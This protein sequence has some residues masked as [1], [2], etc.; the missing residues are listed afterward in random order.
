MRSASTALQ[1][2][3]MVHGVSSRIGAKYTRQD[4]LMLR[5]VGESGCS[6]LSLPLVSGSAT[7]AVRSVLLLLGLPP[8]LLQV[9]G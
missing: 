7:L 6:G 2:L 3:V 5:A 9:A 1:K 8:V 4:G